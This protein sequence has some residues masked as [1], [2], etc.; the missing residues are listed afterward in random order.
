MSNVATRI[1]AWPERWLAA[2]LL[3]ISV[4]M[5]TPA[6]AQDALRFTEA[7]SPED[8][9]LLKLRVQEP[10][11][12]CGFVSV[13]L[14][15]GDTKSPRIRLAVVVI[16]AFDKT[17][18][19]PDP[20]FL[21][22]GGPG[23]STISGFGQVLL[24]DPAKRP[25]LSRDLV[26]WDQRGTYFSQPRLLCR[27]VGQLAA[28]ADEEK[29]KEAYRRCGERLAKEAGDLSAFNSLE[30]ARDVDAVR[31][32]LG[33]EQYNFYGVSYGTELG[34]FL[35]RLR[36]P[37][38]RSVVLDAVVPL[39]FSLVTDVPAVKQQVMQQYARACEESPP[40]N[41]AYPSLA[42]RYL[43]LLDR[44]DKEP[45][46]YAQLDTKTASGKP[47]VT[48]SSLTGK[49]F[50]SILYQS[51][52]VREAVSLIPYVV[53]RAE[54]GDFSFALNM[55]ALLGA[56]QDDMADGMY[57]TVV[58]SEYGD[59]PETALR[60]PGVLKRLADAAETDA[61]QVL[62][63]CRD[64]RIRLLDKALLERVQSDIPTLL[65]SGR[66]DPITP[67]AHADRVAA[68]L[69]RA[70][71]VTFAG[72]T[73]GQAF[74][75]PCA[76]RIIA[77][78]L[79][80]PATAPDGTCAQESAPVFVTP[81]QVISLPGR[82]RGGT[83]TIQDHVLA[84]RGPVV[85]LLFALALLFS[86][87]PVYAVTE[88]VRVFRSRDLHLPDGWRVR[89]IAAAP[90]VPVLTG[91]MLLAFLVAVVAS[92]G[93]AVAR[94]QLLLLIGVVPA[95]VK[96]LTWGMLPFVLSLTL[97]TLA[98]VLLW[99]YRARSRMGRLYYTLL[100]LTGWYVCFALLR[101]GLFGW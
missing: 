37:H 90:W 4:T 79:D 66:F 5:G 56:S 61:K 29:Q 39:G 3:I 81:D 72:G 99:R 34:Q 89:L 60:F 100:V 58:C 32:A 93:N 31:A 9:E 20:L 45:V 12:A 1:H 76:N 38:L 55:A 18:R 15:H 8:C 42:A 11:P 80:A 96:E 46:P 77:A 35:M 94:N 57:M 88:I 17:R 36:P 84:L 23:G 63:L 40:C 48:R 2:A 87:V 59:T 53:T 16:P 7:W 26:L 25:T 67:P 43:S 68:G 74:T 62:T 83:A 14:R 91:L 101:T 78:F 51:V 28:G 22:Q 70:F 71:R 49:D 50:D 92:V 52:Y 86:A 98:M 33:Y 13:P 54:E 24:D 69:T 10:A 65:L 73:H 75:V 6:V 30:N 27:E 95:W 19:Q 64:W 41:A 44:L 85:A 97:M 47:R 21:A 82:K